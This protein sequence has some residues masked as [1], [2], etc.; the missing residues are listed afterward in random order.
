MRKIWLSWR[1]TAGMNKD[2]I[3][4]AYI[5]RLPMG[6]NIYGVEAAARTYFSIPASDLNLA[7][8]SSPRCYS[9]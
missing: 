9:Q 7:Q 5:N 8:A 3:L 1:L 6:G 2:E 4:S